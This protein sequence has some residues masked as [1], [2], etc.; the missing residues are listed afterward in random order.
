MQHLDDMRD[1]FQRKF[2]DLKPPV[3]A[4]NHLCADILAWLCMQIAIR[5]RQNLSPRQL[6][7]PALYW[8][9]TF[10]FLA[11]QGSARVY[12]SM[13]LATIPVRDVAGLF[14]QSEPVSL[15]TTTEADPS[16]VDCCMMTQCLGV[17]LRIA[18]KNKDNQKRRATFFD[19]APRPL[20]GAGKKPSLW[21]RYD[22]WSRSFP[23]STH[24]GM[25]SLSV[26][27]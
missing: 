4:R 19:H 20:A 1:D 16:A 2:R 13:M 11:D 7:S 12:F 25:G 18:I 26:V 5:I 9:Q 8:Q 6:L 17:L 23:T 15:P 27:V 22:R 10:S 3:E 21:L 24:H 14:I